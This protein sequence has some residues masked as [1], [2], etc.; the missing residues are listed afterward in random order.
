MNEQELGDYA[1]AIIKGRYSS[2]YMFATANNM[3][4]VAVRNNLEKLSNGKEPSEKFL[5]AIGYEKVIGDD[6]AV[7]YQVKKSQ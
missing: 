7:T 4:Q 2:M 1:R 6:G 5:D 3:T